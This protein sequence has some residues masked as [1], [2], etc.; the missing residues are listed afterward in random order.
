MILN[1]LFKSHII[2]HMNLFF[3]PPVHS[4]SALVP[5]FKACEVADQLV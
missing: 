2:K 5:H 3:S 4:Y 1:P